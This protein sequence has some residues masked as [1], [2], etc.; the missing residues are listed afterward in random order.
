MRLFSNNKPYNQYQFEKEI[1]F[2]RDIVTNSKLFFGIN[3]IFIDAKKKI[4]SKNLGNSIPDGFLFDLS[5]KGNPEFYIVEVELARHDFYKHIFPQITK[6]FGFY[7]NPTNLSSLVDKMFDFIKDDELLRREFKRYLGDQEIYKFLKDTIDRSQN[8]L[9]I[10]DEDKKEL[11]EI[12]ETYSDTWGKMVKLMLVKKFCNGQESIYSV[13]PEFENI[14]FGE[15]SEKI[16]EADEILETAY[17]EEYHLEGVSESIRQVYSELKSHVLGLNLGVALN[18]QKYYISIRTERN[19]AFLITQRKKARLVVKQAEEI[20]RSEIKNHF[21][22]TLTPKVQK[23]WNG[24]S[25]AIILEDVKNLN[26][27]KVL[28]TKLINEAK[29]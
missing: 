14:E 12:M 2:E 13:H 27:V 17:T 8:I 19:I 23:F 15:L 11:P 4:E 3:S 6:F 28:L 18:P 29:A 22:K 26:E 7:R 1:D 21:I 20:T 5:D 25:C 24:P 9:L 16:E 10:I